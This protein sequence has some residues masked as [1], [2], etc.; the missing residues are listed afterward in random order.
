M[1]KILITGCAGY[2]GGTFC[3]EA[4][5]NN[6]EVLGIDNFINST[7]KNI[8]SFEKKFSKFKFINLDLSVAQEEVKDI[9]DD[10]APNCI[11]HFAGLKA[12]E[13]SENK[14]DLYWQNNV[15]STL[16]IMKA[17]SQDTRLIFS[18]SATV[19]GES[20][21]QPITEKCP[22]KAESVYGS[23]KIASELVI[24]D[25]S[26]KKNIEAICLRYFNPVGSHKDG[27]IIE[28]YTNKPSNLMPK[29]IE[30]VKNKSNAISVFGN[31]YNTEDGTGERDYIH[32]SDLVDGHFAAIN[33]AYKNGEKLFKT[34]NLGTGKATS[35]LQL[36]ESFS[37][38]NEVSID[39]NF[40]DRRKG[41][42]EVC[43]A[44]PS[45]AN[46]DL[47][48]KAVHNIDEMCRDAWNAVKHDN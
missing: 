45:L 10:F 22:I 30:A 7:D 3:Y 15:L 43:Y 1:K 20:T 12:V 8:K 25:Y 18:S 6:Y 14:P 33:F 46:H 44:D 13:E 16:N 21:I 17:C 41:D 4:L 37:R 23:T 47:K 40:A 42:I 31:N 19:Y 26:R 9:F 39:I 34:Y 38:V 5:K 11:V 2:I 28:D 27:V 36:I 32:I 29:L 24:K 35:V 48:W